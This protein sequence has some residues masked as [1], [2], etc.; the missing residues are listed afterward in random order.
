MAT[1]AGF[2]RMPASFVR[3]IGDG[4]TREFSVP[5]NYLSP[6]HVIVRVD[7]TISGFAWLTESTVQLTITPSNGQIV[8]IKRETP[9][10]RPLVDFVDGS[11][12]TEAD[13]DRATLQG[14]YAAQEFADQITGT[15]RVDST[16]NW[17]AGSKTI[18]NLPFPTAD[19]H[20][21]T[22]GYVDTSVSSQVAQAAASADEAKGY[23]NAAST[24]AAQADNSSSIAQSRA[25]EVT[26]IRDQL[27]ALNVATAAGATS[28]DYAATYD[29]G[30]GTLTITIP[31]GIQ[32]PEGPV[33]PQGPRGNEGPVGPR[34]PDGIQGSQ[35][36]QG[37]PGPQGPIGPQGPA[38]PEGDPGPD[39]AP[40]ADGAPGPTGDP[41]PEGPQGPMGATPLG[42]AFGQFKIDTDGV[43]SIEFYGDASDND[44][45]IDAEGNLFVTTV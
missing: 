38:G 21:A 14:L 5:F 12:L 40:G 16:G 18:T 37:D 25:N 17:E 42:L 8:E 19:D 36:P 15:L 41:G 30:T 9:S 10:D 35:G 29:P 43:L 4:S 11:T 45:R 13:L 23:R 34:G 28:S 3:Y 20:A 39:G 2:F 33:G 27:Y 1:R 22:K 31:Q 26:T 6:R 44:F 7:G 24:F 32:G